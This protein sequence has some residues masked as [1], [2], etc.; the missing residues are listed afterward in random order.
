MGQWLR[1]LLEGEFIYIT[2]IGLIAPIFSIFLRD[3]IF[4]ATLLTIGIAEG[5]FLLTLAILRPFTQLT[6]QKDA[7]GW[8]TQHFFWY[9]GLLVVL[10]PFLYLLARDMIDIYVIQMLYGLGIAFCEPAWIRMTD[11]TCKIRTSTN[12]EQF[13]TV[14]TLLAAGMAAL[15]GYVAHNYGIKPLFIFIGTMLAFTIIGM[16]AIYYK[17]C[18]Y[19]VKK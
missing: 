8:R 4:D 5:I 2:A 9:G 16:N 19:Q 18:L 17:L 7:K 15:A 10:V 14:G 1:L 6:T 12:W 3:T 13:N 11:L